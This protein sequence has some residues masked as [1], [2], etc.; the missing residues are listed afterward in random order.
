ITIL[1]P[2]QATAVVTPGAGVQV[3]VGGIT[4]GF[5]NLRPG[6]NNTLFDLTVS[7]INLAEGLNFVTAAVRV[8]DV[9]RNAN[10]NPAP[11]NG[12][13]QLSNPL[14]LT[15]DTIAPAAPSLP[16]LLPSSDSGTL[17]NDN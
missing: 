11:A 13:T 6:S 12:R 7:P 1:R 9:Q 14:L 2:A 4:V 17:N 16:V 8:F 15:L 3:F 10:G 5:A